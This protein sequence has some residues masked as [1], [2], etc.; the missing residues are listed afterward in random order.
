MNGISFAALVVLLCL[1]LVRESRRVHAATVG[2]PRRSLAASVELVLWGA[3][4]AL[5]L[6]RLVELLT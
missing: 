1:L 4:A 5:V 3:C 2:P 6:P